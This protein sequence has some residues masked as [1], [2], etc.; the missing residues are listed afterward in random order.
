MF[1]LD[2]SSLQSVKKFANEVKQIY[3]KIHILLNLGKYRFNLENKEL[4]LILFYLQLNQMLY[5]PDFSVVSKL[6]NLANLLVL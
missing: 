1:E 6:S 2:T 5:I 4:A 3:S